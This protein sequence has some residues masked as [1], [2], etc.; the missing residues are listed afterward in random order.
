[1]LL[2]M[3]YLYLQADRAVAEAQKSF[4]RQV[5]TINELL[6]QIGSSDLKN[7]PNSQAI[8]RE[9]LQKAEAFYSKLGS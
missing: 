3:T 4:Q 8:R 9:L 2:A 1:M 7:I 6:V 5:L